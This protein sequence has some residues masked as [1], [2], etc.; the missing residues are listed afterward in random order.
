MATGAGG[1]S[2]WSTGTAFTTLAAPVLST[3][4]GT[5]T[6]AT[7]ANAGAT[8]DTVSGSGSRIMYALARVG[9]SPALSGPIIASGTQINVTASGAN[10]VP[11]T[12]L[13]TNVGAV[14]DVVYVDATLGTSN[15]VTTGTFT[16]AT[17]AISG[18]ALSAQS[19]G[20]GAALTWAGVTPESTVTNTGVGTPGT[21]W[22][23]LSGAGASGATCNAASGILVVSSGGTVGSYTITL[24]RADASTPTP[25]TVTKTA[26]LTV[27]STAAT[28]VTLSGPSGGVVGVASANFTVGVTPGG[29]TISGTLVVTPNDSGGGG[30][31]TPSSVNLT[32]G[33]PTA[34]ITYTPTSVGAKTIGVTNAGGL[35]NPTTLT[36]TSSGSAATAVTLTGP[37]TGIAGVAS[38]NFTVG[39]NGVITGTVSVT[40]SASGCTFTPSSVNISSGSPTATFTCTPAAAGAK[41]ITLANNGSLSNP[42]AWTYT[43]SAALA[44][45]VSIT[46]TTDGTTPAANLTGLKVAV[47]DQSTPDLWTGHAPIYA[48]SV[49]S[50]NGSGV[51]TCNIS[52]VTNLAPGAL[53]GLVV[54]SSDGTL[55]Q[56]A[57]QKGYVGPAL[58]S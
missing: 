9:G 23:V 16:P 17:L 53:A 37:T 14:A 6:G 7:T 48:T 44:T 32:T 42:S 25:Q 27:T 12:A 19:V 10:L 56:G 52:G 8:I 24:Q 33:S 3:P 30:T 5:A 11:L 55:T 46:L 54:S 15:V 34:T 20:Q 13:T 2:A 22:T 40:P 57:A 39:A 36:Y 51:L 41:S 45:S 29:G 38:T 28:G 58:V 31:F 1:D 35:S 26:S 50:T 47:F 49:G 18:T 21:P 43:A 4:V